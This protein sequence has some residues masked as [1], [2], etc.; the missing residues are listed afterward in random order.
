MSNPCSF[1]VVWG[2]MV[3]VFV[4]ITQSVINNC[5]INFPVYIVTHGPYRAFRNLEVI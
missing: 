3:R 1:R 2:E 4:I 5:V